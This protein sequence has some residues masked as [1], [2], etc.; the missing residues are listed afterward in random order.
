MLLFQREFLAD[1][2]PTYSGPTISKATVFFVI[3]I[4]IIIVIIIPLHLLHKTKIG[5]RDL[6]Y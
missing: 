1:I 4:K 3:I 6:S 5:V 2:F